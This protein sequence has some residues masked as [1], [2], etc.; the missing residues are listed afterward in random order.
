MFSQRITGI[1][2]RVEGTFE[3]REQE[4]IVTSIYPF[5]DSEAGLDFWVGGWG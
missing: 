5:C 3:V 4:F 2:N 1:W